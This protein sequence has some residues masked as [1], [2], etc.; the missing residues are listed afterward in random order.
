MYVGSCI[1]QFA[2]I[3][4]SL[5]SSIASR[6]V[7]QIHELGHIQGALFALTSL[8]EAIGPI[9]FNY[10]YNNIHLFGTGTFFIFGAFL[11]S[12]GTITVSFISPQTTTT[13]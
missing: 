1:A 4:I 7:N 12:I 8:A 2:D 11:Y 6:N 13:T 5:L 9:L 10:I 3:N